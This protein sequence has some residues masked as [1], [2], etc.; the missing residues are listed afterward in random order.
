MRIKRF[1]GDTYPESFILN[2]NNTPVNLDLVSTIEFSVR[3]PN[4]VQTLSGV[5]N[6]D[7]ASGRVVFEFTT[8]IAAEV[9]VFPYD[10]EGVYVD[11]IIV[12]FV[13]DTISFADDVNKP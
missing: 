2:T 3:K 11:G 10:I 6:V 9:G 13:K 1:R 8:E 4:G 12:T 5:K 7:A